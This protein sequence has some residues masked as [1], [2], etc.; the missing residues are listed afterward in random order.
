MREFMVG[1]G[2]RFG[3]SKIRRG[4]AV[5]WDNLPLLH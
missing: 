3:L 1:D 4:N 5:I 2:R